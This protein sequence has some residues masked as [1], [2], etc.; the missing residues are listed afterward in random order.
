MP[1]HLISQEQPLYLGF[2]SVPY[3]SSILNS[4]PHEQPY[5]GC[6]LVEEGKPCD[7]STT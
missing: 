4:T 6:V 2:G 3:V 1:P 5:L 7:V